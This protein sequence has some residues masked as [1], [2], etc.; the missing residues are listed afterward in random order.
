MEFIPIVGN[1]LRNIGN[2]LSVVSMAHGWIDIVHENFLDDEVAIAEKE[3]TATCLYQ[4]RDDQL[5]YYRDENDEPVLARTAIVAIDTDDDQSMW[6]GVGDNVTAYFNIGHAAI[7]GRTPYYMRFVN[8]LALQI[9]S[10]D[11]DEVVA[12]DSTIIQDKLRDPETKEIGM[13]DSENIYMLSEGE[14]HL[15]YENVE[16]ESDYTVSLDLTDSAT[17]SVN[18]QTLTGSELSF[19][20]YVGE[21]E[22]ISIDLRGNAVGLKGSVS[23]LPNDDPSDIGFISPGGKYIL[24]TELSGIKSLD[25]DNTDLIIEDIFICEDGAFVSYESYIPFA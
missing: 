15:V 13:F 24:R 4:N 1:V 14:D 10:S 18:G 21:H 20:V 16:Y 23:I 9:V 25:T 17:V 19:N 8:Q 6:Y 12:A 22:D 5:K 3:I 7:D 2:I 11:G